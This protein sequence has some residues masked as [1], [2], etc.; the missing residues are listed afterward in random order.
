MSDIPLQKREFER[1]LQ[2]LLQTYGRD[3]DN[4][5][6]YQS[7]SSQRCHACMF[8]T[9]SQDCFHCTYCHQC[10][11]CSDCTHC[12]RSTN[13]TQSSYCTDAHH[14]IKS[15]YML[16]SQHCYECVFCFGCV[17]LVKKEFH[18]LNQPFPRKV[19]FEL[20]AQLKEAFGLN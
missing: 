7:D 14:C 11:E 19:Y 5:T 16:M 2:T 13:C 12:T 17:G 18:I 20:V 1:A 3:N 4:P 10:K 15:S 6:S 8:T 9:Q